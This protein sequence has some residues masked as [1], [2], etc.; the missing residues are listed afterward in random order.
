MQQAGAADRRSGLPKSDI[1]CP[2][3][4]VSFRPMRRAALA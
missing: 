3:L 4:P 2:I 1:D